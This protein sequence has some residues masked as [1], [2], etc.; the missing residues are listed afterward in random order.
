MISGSHRE[1]GL[2]GFAVKTIISASHGKFTIELTLLVGILPV[3]GGVVNEGRV[4]EWCLMLE[5]KIA[6]ASGHSVDE[7]LVEW[8]L[9]CTI[10][11]DCPGNF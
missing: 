10:F 9:E 1:T 11:E 2:E 5:S 4:F 3:F 6:V 8:M 7:G